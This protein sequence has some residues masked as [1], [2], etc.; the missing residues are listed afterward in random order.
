M[1]VSGVFDFFRG[2]C[3]KFR[4]WAYRRQPLILLPILY[5]FAVRWQIKDKKQ[6]PEYYRLHGVI[7]FTGL[8]GSGK[9]TSAVRH[10]L[11]C[12]RNNPE[13]KFYSNQKIAGATLFDNIN[14]IVAIKESAIFFIDE[15]H[16]SYH[17]RNWTNFPFELIS[18]LSQNRKMA[19]YFIFAAQNFKHVDGQIRDQCRYIVDCHSFGGIL[20]FNSWWS[21]LKYEQRH[22]TFERRPYATKFDIF[23]GYPELFDSFGSLE[24]L[25]RLKN[26]RRKS[27][28]DERANISPFRR[29]S[30]PE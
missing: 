29:R 10:C 27:D 11:E 2:V 7:V 28:G 4:L 26:D 9:T 19:K 14:D 30:L 24:K 18:E 23:V 22:I 6:H 3:G 5:V 16:L 1:R 25:G 20:F 12:V 15:S 21:P 17:S 8:W 13:M